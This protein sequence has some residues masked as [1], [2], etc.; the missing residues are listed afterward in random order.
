M[1]SFLHR[2]PAGSRALV[3]LFMGSTRGDGRHQCVAAQSHRA[4]PLSLGTPLLLSVD[5]AHAWH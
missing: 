1:L 3:S 4:E 5:S 2:Q